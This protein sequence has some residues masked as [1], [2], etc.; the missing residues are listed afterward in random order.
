MIGRERGEREREAAYCL[1]AGKKT[2]REIKEDREGHMLG[3]GT[4][5][6]HPTS[7]TDRNGRDVP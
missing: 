5:N 1:M 3:P 6:S 7:F 4:Q 2:E